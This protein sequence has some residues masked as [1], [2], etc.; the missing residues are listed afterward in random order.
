MGPKKHLLQSKCKYHGPILRYALSEECEVGQ[1]LL[2]VREREESDL[3]VFAGEG[4][5]PTSILI[6]AGAIYTSWY[7]LVENSQKG[8]LRGSG[9]L[10]NAQWV[11]ANLLRNW[12]EHCKAHH[13]ECHPKPAVEGLYTG[14]PALLIDTWRM[15]LTDARPEAS[16]VAL[17][18]V[19]GNVST[20]RTTKQN[21][22]DLQV[23][24]ALSY[25]M[26][27]SKIPATISHAIQLVNLLKERYLWVD[28]LC[29]VQDDDDVRHQQINAMASIYFNSLLTIIAAEG[30]DAQH[31]IAG[32]R[33][34]SQ[35]RSCSQ[36]KFDL[37]GTGQLIEVPWPCLSNRRWF[38]RGWTFQEHIFS[39]RRLIFGDYRVRWECKE[40]SWQEDVDYNV[41]PSASPYALKAESMRFQMEDLC[42]PNVSYYF[43]HVCK[44]NKRDF[45]YA[46]D[47]FF[48][49]AGFVSLVRS[50]FAGG[51]LYGLPEMFFDDAMLWQPSQTLERR[52]AKHPSP[53]AFDFQL[54]SWSWMG[55][56]GDI[57]P[58][59]FSS[60]NE[61]IMEYSSGLEAFVRTIST[62]QWYYVSI[63]AANEK[64]PIL[65]TCKKYSQLSSSDSQPLPPGWTKHSFDWNGLTL[66]EKHHWPE[67]H[68]TKHF[69]EHE[70]APQYFWY[71][72]PEPSN[73]PYQD[74]QPSPG[75]CLFC[76]T[77]KTTFSA[78]R[79]VTSYGP[80][81]SLRDDKGIWVGYLTF[82][83]ERELEKIPSWRDKSATPAY[84]D[85]V[86]ISAGFVRNDGIA[87]GLQEFELEERPKNTPLY[88]F[89]NVLWV[90]WDQGIAQRKGLG[91][92]LKSVWEAEE[93]EHI[94][95]MLG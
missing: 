68:S 11:D 7:Q 76:K 79:D 13:Q 66:S 29:I 45:T 46:K 25:L 86:A 62:V 63:Q 82:H 27:M 31:G 71:P 4:R 2:C 61:F 59:S 37:D 19:W 80:G 42:W 34:I 20:F 18:Y 90:V 74:T 5:G 60:A 17:S 81:A 67:K 40:E 22:A 26:Q 72:F 3:A 57:D 85:L 58:W 73:Q 87:H 30:S 38:S 91:R 75:A 16:Y 15:C 35:P 64:R 89:Y 23:D 84:F 28:I 95:L 6:T 32:L 43:E 44:Y 48:A 12:K 10:I 33:G 83:D 70:N 52:L 93:R 65:V 77:T 39:H 47:A 78:T 49:L 94:D 51:F 53:Q 36:R 88:E 69:Y 55:W 14:R 92:V 54:P 1:P 24:Q 8:S 21:L 56:R 41:S 50:S 9:R